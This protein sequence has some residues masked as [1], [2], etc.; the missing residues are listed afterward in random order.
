M[1]DEPVLCE[2]CGEGMTLAP[3]I[4]YFC[5]NDSCG[6]KHMAKA[7]KTVQEIRRRERYEQ[8]LKLKEEFDNG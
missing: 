6:P 8:Y 1:D 5:E 7:M 3:G 4:D 2:F